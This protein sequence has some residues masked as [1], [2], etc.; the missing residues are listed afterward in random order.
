[1]RCLVRGRGVGAERKIMRLRAAKKEKEAREIV[2]KERE[3]ERVYVRQ[4]FL[5]TRGKEDISS[6]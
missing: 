5:R 6:R 1:M 3:R 2:A 4:I